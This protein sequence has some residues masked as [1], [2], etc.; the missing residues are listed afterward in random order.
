MD[1][2]NINGIDL[3]YTRHG[4]G[5]PLVLIHGFPLDHH[6]W[7]DVIPL[8]ENTFDLIIPDLRGFGE[9]TITDTFCR[10]EDYASDIAKLLD[11]LGVLKTAIAGHSM[12]G[13]IALAFTRL[14]PERVRGLGLVASQI[15]AD[16]PERK[17]GRYKSAADV[18]DKGISVV[19]DAMAPKFTP[20]EKLQAVARKMME[21]QAPTA[22]IN[23][24][25]AMA[26]RQD[27]T[28][29]LGEIN[30]PVVIVHGEVDALIPVERALEVK[31]ALPYAVLVE[32]SGAG[33]LPML[34]SAEQTA[35][36]LKHLA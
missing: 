3:A 28:P 21:R 9:S 25:K 8:L 5:I 4:Q 31:L 23:A 35:Q 16:P 10:M 24:L 26:E 22:Y 36:S 6:V 13:Y 15:L 7:D 19:V 11:H 14:Y 12:G 33:H 1:K 27:S 17:E 30:Y 2:I 34:E 29:L 18:A 20:D 32:L